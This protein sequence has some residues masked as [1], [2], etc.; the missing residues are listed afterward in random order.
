MTTV[1]REDAWLA[2][3]GFAMRIWETD[4]VVVALEK[5]K[6]EADTMR[7]NGFPYGGDE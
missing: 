3:V 1:T 4:D 6:I 7:L 2:A 5:V